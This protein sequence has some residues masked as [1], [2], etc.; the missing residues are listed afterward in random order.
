[1]RRKRFFSMAVAALVAGTLITALTPTAALAAVRIKN[2]G[3]KFL[4]ASG[5]NVIVDSLGL[6]W[7]EVNDGNYITFYR[8][9][10]SLNL[11]LSGNSSAVGTRAVLTTPSGNFT[12]DWRIEFVNNTQFRLHSRA[13]DGR[14]LGVSGGSSGTNVALFTCDGTSN[15]RWSR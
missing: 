15:Q 13:S 12:Q 11:G 7:S 5:N 9:S 6:A 3:G 10:Q 1:M 4:G 8:S 2:G 14:C